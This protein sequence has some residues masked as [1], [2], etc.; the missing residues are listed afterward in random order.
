MKRELHIFSGQMYFS[1]MDDRTSTYL[2]EQS[3]LDGSGRHVLVNCSEAA[4]SLSIDFNSR[5]LYYAYKETGT[6]SYVDLE[7]RKVSNADLRRQRR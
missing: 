4:T 2:I 1:H 7:T 5:R 6:I 3:A